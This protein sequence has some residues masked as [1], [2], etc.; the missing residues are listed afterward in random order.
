MNFIARLTATT[1][2]T[3][4]LTVSNDSNTMIQRMIALLVAS[5]TM[6]TPKIGR[7]KRVPYFARL[8]NYCKVGRFGGKSS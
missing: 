1:V 7:P 6:L 2:V 8:S 4:I 5:A 3:V